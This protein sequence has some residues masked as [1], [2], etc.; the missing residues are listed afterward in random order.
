[1]G[2]GERSKIEIFFQ[3][4]DDT[5]CDYEIA[6]NY[7]ED[8][9]C[10]YSFSA[11]VYFP[12]WGYIESVDETWMVTDIGWGEEDDAYAGILEVANGT[13]IG[14][15][16]NNVVHF[17]TLT[18][19]NSMLNVMYGGSSMFGYTDEI[20]GFSLPMDGN[21]ILQTN[22]C[23]ED[24][25]YDLEFE[26]IADM[27]YERYGAAYTTDG[28]FVYAI[29]GADTAN[30]HTHGERY[31]PDTDTWE[32]FAEDLIPRRYTNAE[33]LNGN[34]YLFNGNN[35]TN[36]VE[37]INVSTGEVSHSET[38]PYPVVYGGS[39]VWNG[40]IYL[41]GGAHSDGYSNRLY[42]FDPANES[43]T[44]L[45]DMPESKQTSGRVVDG[46]LYTIGGYNGDVSSKIHAYVIAQDSWNTD[47]ADMP[48]GISAHSS[49]TNGEE[50]VAIGDYSN[51]EFSGLYDPAEDS[52]MVLDNNME[53]RRHSASVYLNGSIY[54]FGGSQP[55]GY[56]G[57]TE[58]VVL[59][60]AE[61][62]DISGGSNCSDGEVELWG[63]CYSIEN[64]TSLNLAN[65]E[66]TGEI[67]PE[68]GNLTH[69][70][71]LHLSYNQLTG[72]I[73]PE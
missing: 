54:A 63:E 34:I 50:I 57:N 43:W 39:A 46:I 49:V 9:E 18:F 68:I 59:R 22:Q 56:N 51:I 58:Y 11:A 40:K 64:T 27:I 30:F 21:N 14:D 24:T 10:L 15:S 62:A 35:S 52:F 41:F 6:C 32:I 17:I 36:V 42:E 45:A 71:E 28:E 44:Q 67:P 55:Q 33:Y 70:T 61:R 3:E 72:E 73:P 65:S 16:F 25:D 1:W 4:D 38:N 66:L 23:E 69:L 26:D 60:S 7:G 37:I 20:G 2:Q 13:D 5:G 47:L 8:S 12:D 48:V 53:G 29:C 19:D 31:N